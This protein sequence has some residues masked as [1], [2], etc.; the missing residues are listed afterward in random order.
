MSIDA[1]LADVVYDSA[2]LTAEATGIRGT[3]ETRGL[4]YAHGDHVVELEIQ[5]THGEV[6]LLGQ[7]DPANRVD[8]TVRQ[9]DRPV[10]T[11][12][13]DNLG[14]F[15]VSG[16]SGGPLAVHVPALSLWTGVITP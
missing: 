12:R 3:A 1:E 15:R 16:L 2:E 14:Q 10:I 5:R 8:V 11:V 4:T 7:I 13:S 6:V 9:L